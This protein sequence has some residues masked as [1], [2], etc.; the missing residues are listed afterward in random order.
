MGESERMSIKLE[1]KLCVVVVFVCF[2]F[3]TK[4]GRISEISR[5]S[6]IFL[7][8]GIERISDLPSLS[9]TCLI[10]ACGLMSE[11]ASFGD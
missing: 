2:G 8:S 5:N 10:F 3:K 7:F 6:V 4:V 11:T 9:P 1:V